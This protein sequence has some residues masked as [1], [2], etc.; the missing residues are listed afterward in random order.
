M[1]LLVDKSPTVITLTERTGFG[2]THL[3]AYQSKYQT[4][5][6]NGDL[7]N[8][9]RRHQN[10]SQSWLSNQTDQLGKRVLVREESKNPTVADNR[11]LETRSSALMKAT[12]NFFTLLLSIMFVENTAPLLPI[13]IPAVKHSFHKMYRTRLMC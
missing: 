13:T 6:V 9:E 8:T 1:F 3:L 12:L 10:F 5:T 11:L 7:E 2:N 4:I